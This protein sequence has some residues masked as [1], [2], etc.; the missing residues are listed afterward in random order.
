[1]SEDDLVGPAAGSASHGTLSRRGPLLQVTDKVGVDS[2][3]VSFKD[4]RLV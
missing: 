2:A 4:A 1:M 3:I